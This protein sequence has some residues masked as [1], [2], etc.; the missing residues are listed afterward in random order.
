[1]L[2]SYND[3]QNDKIENILKNLLSFLL[4]YLKDALYNIY[5]ITCVN[6]MIARSILLLINLKYLVTIH[7]KITIFAS[8]SS[9][10]VR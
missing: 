1:V 10:S 2:P 3:F 9:L 4:Y 7:F 5:T 8:R 6:K